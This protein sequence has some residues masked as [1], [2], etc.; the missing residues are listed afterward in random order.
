MIASPTVWIFSTFIPEQPHYKRQVPIIARVSWVSICPHNPPLRSILLVA[1]R[2]EDCFPQTSPEQ[3]ESQQAKPVFVRP[4]YLREDPWTPTT[5]PKDASHWTRVRQ[6]LNKHDGAT[7]SS[8][9]EEI[10]TQLIVV[11]D[12]IPSIQ[13]FPF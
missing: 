10:N 7:I 4:P 9:Q 6:L 3:A 12:A 2:Q 1:D 8:W 5:P 11:S 13:Q